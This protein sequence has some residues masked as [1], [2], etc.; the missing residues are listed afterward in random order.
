MAESAGEAYARRREA[1]YGPL[2][3]QGVFTWDSMYGEEYA[4]ASVLPVSGE[5]R[6]ELK[7]ASEALGAI[8]ARTSA[9]VMQAADELLANL[10]LP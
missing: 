9:V 5:F 8:F 2:R 10:G 7:R 4:L 1:I 6:A 3:Q